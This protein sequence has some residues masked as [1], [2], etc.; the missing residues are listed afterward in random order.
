MTDD[1][2][3]FSDEEFSSFANERSS[4]S[5]RTSAIC[6]RSTSRLQALNVTPATI[7]LLLKPGTSQTTLVP[8]IHRIFNLMVPESSTA[9]PQNAF[10]TRLM[11]ET[12]DM[13][14]TAQD[15]VLRLVRALKLIPEDKQVLVLQM[16]EAFKAPNPI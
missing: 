13:A 7:T 4:F 14:P 8:A 5:T 2:I 15:L 6:N 12:K 16:T 11:R 10:A 9:S 3:W 1:P